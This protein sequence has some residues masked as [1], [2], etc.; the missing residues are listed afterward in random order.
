MR[1]YHEQT[2]ACDR[3]DRR[4]AHRLVLCVDLEVLSLNRQGQRDALT[5]SIR[6]RIVMAARLLPSILSRRRCPSRRSSSLLA[7]APYSALSWDLYVNIGATSSDLPSWW[8]AI[9]PRRDPEQVRSVLKDQQG[10]RAQG[11]NY[12]L[13]LRLVPV[14]LLPDQP[15]RG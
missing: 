11:F 2:E 4:N 3:S 6:R 8:P 9:F 10:T 5:R 14:F 7:A 1:R 12:L 13:F 15:W